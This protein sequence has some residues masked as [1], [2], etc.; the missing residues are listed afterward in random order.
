L[1]V[2]PGSDSFS[3]DYGKRERTMSRGIPSICL[4][5][6]TGQAVVR[7]DGKDYYLGKYGTPQVQQRYDRLIAEWLAGKRSRPVPGESGNGFTVDE[8]LVRYWRWAES[9]YRDDDGRPARELENIRDALKP[10]RRLYGQTIAKDFG[11]LAIRTLQQ[12]LASDGL[13]RTTV[14]MRVTRIRRVFKWAVSVELLP[15][16]VHQA[17]ATVPGL[18]R[19]REQAKEAEPIGPAPVEHIE[20]AILH[21]PR[22]VATMAQLQLLTASRAGEIMAMRAIDLNMSGPIWTYT[23]KRHKNRHRGH[24]R[25]IFLGPKAQEIIKSFLTTDLNAYLFSPRR[26]MEQMHAQRAAL[27]KSKRTP[28]EQRR[29]RKRKPKIKLGERYNRRSYRIAVD[30]AC[31]KANVPSWSP[32]Q[33]RHTAATMIRSKYGIEAAKVVLAHQCIETSQIYAE[34]DLGKAAQIIA[35]IG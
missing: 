17:L 28:S 7:L 13:A 5:K 2:R 21:M 11:P 20:A 35:E 8:V 25:V 18:R 24:E 19:G 10:L 22:P 12:H 16:S 33:L 34:R 9:Y 29:T 23:P 14:N 4:H 31:K 30:R 3:V 1:K 26:Y 15:A 6:A 32:L 27:R